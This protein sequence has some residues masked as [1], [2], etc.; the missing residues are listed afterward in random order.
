MIDLHTHILPGLD[1]GARDMEEALDMARMAVEDGIQ[2]V[3]ATPH[4][5]RSTSELLDS[6][7]VKK[8]KR[9]LEKELLSGGIPLKVY[10][11]AEVH[12][13]HNLMETIHRHRQELVLN[14]GSYMLLEFPAD[15]LYSDVGRLFFDLMTEGITPVIAHP[16]RN[17]VL[18]RY[19]EKMAEFIVTGVRCQ[20]NSGSLLG[21]YGGASKEAAWNF[22][23]SRCV[24]FL[25]SDCHSTRSLVPHLGKA[26]GLIREK[27]GEKTARALVEDN[28]QAALENRP[29]PFV[30]DPVKRKEKKRTLKIRIPSFLKR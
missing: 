22:L 24:H 4:L 16:E 1:D 26:A 29:L 9:S 25:A 17:S 21:V 20:I 23:E 3:V 11:G 10:L 19:P 8:I 12:I 6:R 13:S 28:P 5:L 7:I 18:A 27:L 15:H 30:P 2:A 14:E